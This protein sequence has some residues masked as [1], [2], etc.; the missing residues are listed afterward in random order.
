MSLRPEFLTEHPSTQI[1]CYLTA[2]RI[3]QVRSAADLADLIGD[4]IVTYLASTGR[5]SSAEDAEIGK[6]GNA[7]IDR[8]VQDA[9]AKLKSAG[10]FEHFSH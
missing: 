3:A 1:D 4:T 7:V 10:Q 5:I 2:E 8:A 6:V 9:L